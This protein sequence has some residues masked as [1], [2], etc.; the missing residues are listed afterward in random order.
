[1]HVAAKIHYVF[2]QD[3]A[4]GSLSMASV[5][6]LHYAIVLTMAW[7]FG[8]VAIKLSEVLDRESGCAQSHVWINGHR[9]RLVECSCFPA[10][11]IRRINGACK[12]HSTN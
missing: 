3:G 10:L 11:R 5:E 1:M 6:T 2:E 12:I 9:Q 7:V 4:G 8:F